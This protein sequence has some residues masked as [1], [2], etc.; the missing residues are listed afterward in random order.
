MAPFCK[1]SND[2]VIIPIFTLVVRLECA[3]ETFLAAHL[4]YT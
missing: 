4:Y 3:A 2:E 1:C